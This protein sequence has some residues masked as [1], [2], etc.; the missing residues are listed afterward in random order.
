VRCAPPNA[1]DV[2]Y[3][4]NLGFAAFD[5]LYNG[6]SNALVTIQNNQ[7]VPIPF[8]EIL[9]PV[10]KKTQVRMVNVNSIQYRI[11]RQY[12]IRIEKEDFESTIDLEKMA[13]VS[14]VTPAEF[15]KRFQYLTQV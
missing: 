7:I 2:E 3:T 13:L 5:F 14:N 6:R 1:Y 12:M 9:D 15:S 8:D 10:T 11:A 4:R